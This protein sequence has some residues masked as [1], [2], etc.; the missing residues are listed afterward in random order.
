MRKILTVALMLAAFAVKAQT[1]TQESLQGKWDVVYMEAEYLTIDLEEKTYTI[2]Q[3]LRGQIGDDISI[4]EESIQEML[5]NN[6]SFTVIF[7][8]TSATYI[9]QYGEESKTTTSFTYT[10][11]Q[12]NPQLLE[13]ISIDGEKKVNEIAFKDGKLE[14]KEQGNTNKMILK[15]TE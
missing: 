1:V 10:L 13:S 2:A 9:Q 11:M 3:E 4:I 14:I 15:K 5:D 7:K 6:Y 8:G 12:G